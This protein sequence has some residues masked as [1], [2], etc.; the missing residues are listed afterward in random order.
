MKDTGNLNKTWWMW[1]SCIACFFRRFTKGVPTGVTQE[2]TSRF[3]YRKQLGCAPS[4]NNVGSEKNTWVHLGEENVGKV[5][6]ERHGSIYIWWQ[7]FSTSIGATG[8]PHPKL[9]LTLLLLRA[10]I[11]QGGPLPLVDGVITPIS[12]VITPLE[13]VGGYLVGWKLL[14]P[15][16]FVS[17]TRVCRPKFTGPKIN[18]DPW[19]FIFPI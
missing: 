14:A 11:V 4:I 17:K 9:L 7:M 15:L 12:R 3:I 5:Y 19:S 10:Q 18:H 6:S 1:Q 8:H 13:L 2:G 16:G